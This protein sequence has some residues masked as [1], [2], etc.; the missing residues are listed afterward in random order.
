ML[1]NSGYSY[2][3]ASIAESEQTAIFCDLQLIWEK[4]KYYHLVVL[5]QS[6]SHFLTRVSLSF[7]RYMGTIT[8]ISDLDAVRWPNSHWRSVKVSKDVNAMCLK[9]W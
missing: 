6:I 3:S 5:H 7:C 4:E 2:S 1:S 9:D 8:G